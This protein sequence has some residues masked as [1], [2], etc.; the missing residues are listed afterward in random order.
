MPTTIEIELP[1]EIIN[2]MRRLLNL[3]EVTEEETEANEA[4]TVD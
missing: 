3:P 4:S 1:I 2:E